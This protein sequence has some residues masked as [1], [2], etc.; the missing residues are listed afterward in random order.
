MF[1]YPLESSGNDRTS[2][3]CSQML[4]THSTTTRDDI[5][6][7]TQ[8]YPQCTDVIQ[9]RHRIHTTNNEN[10]MREYVIN[11][12][13]ST[14]TSY[15]QRISVDNTIKSNNSCSCNTTQYSM[16]IPSES[17]LNGAAPNEWNPPNNSGDVCY[18]N[19]DE[20]PY[21]PNSSAEYFICDAV[22]DGVNIQYAGVESSREVV[23]INIPAGNVNHQEQH[24]AAPS[25]QYYNYTQ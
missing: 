10:N 17:S 15:N 1:Y 3:S 23:T 20:L 7:S 6:T 16:P 14:L 11:R 22:S 9:H 12:P 8:H 21:N 4:H 19:S 2:S 5:P 25:I 24:Q 18:A 13:S